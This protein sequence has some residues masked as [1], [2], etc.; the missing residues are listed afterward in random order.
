MKFINVLIE[1]TTLQLNQTFTYAC[2]YDVQ[3]GMRVK[4]PFA[5]QELIAIVMECDVEYTK[6]NYKYVIEVLDAEPLL[7]EEMFEL[8]NYISNTYVTSLMSC[9]K[10]MLPPALRPSSN[11]SLVQYED[12]FVA[13]ASF[14]PLTPKQA[15][16]W[17]QYKE[18]LPMKASLFRKLAKHHTKALLDK[19]Y[20]TIE[21]REKSQT[22]VSVDSVSKPFDLTQEQSSALHEIHTS[23][24]SVFLLHGVTGS[25][26]TEIF[27]RL[28]QEVLDQG[29]QV[30]FLV[31]EIG[32]TPMIISRVMARFQQNIAIYHSQLNASEKYQQY[33]MVKNKQVNIVVGTRS[34]CFMPFH[35]L[36]LILMD[37]EHDTSYKQD[38]MPKYHTRDIVLFRAQKHHCKVVLASA[39]P[40]LESYA[41]A[42][43]GIY[44]L[45]EMKHRVYDQMPSIQLVNLK[46][47]FVQDGLSQTLIDKM[48]DRLAK[49][50]QV[51]L[52]L[53]RR[54]YLP[55]VRCIDCNEVL[56]CPDCG[57]ALSY[58]KSN[59]ALM[60]HCCGNVYPKPS[61]CPSCG[62]RMFSTTGMGTEKLEDKIQERFPQAHVV[63]MDADSTRKKNA[64]E[65]LLKEFEQSG[66][67][68]IGTQMVA[69]GLD[70]PR[71]TLVGI[72]QADSA[73]TR[74][75]YRACE[76]AY[77]MLEQAS[78]RCGREKLAGEVIIQTFDEDHYVMKSVVAHDYAS[79]FA[80]EMQYRHLGQYPPYVYMATLI[81]VHPDAEK[82]RQ[83]ALEAKDFLKE[84]RVLGPIDISM[85]MKKSRVR[86]LIKDK[87]EQHLQA[88]IWNWVHHEKEHPSAVKTEINMHPLMLED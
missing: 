49:N 23:P 65:K 6:A 75:D 35:D 64:H 15:E 21:T 67:I 3:R 12:W 44:H 13:N 22:L 18:N 57:I 4:V 81:F 70:F 45:I 5:H 69:K 27:L 61:A 66:D 54:G 52:L 16:I 72:L 26:K 39:T 41:R 55:T 68:L 11:H 60:C 63:R 79:F 77:E 53:N 10:T 58:H 40:C 74:N 73:L 78:G 46:N 85:R 25:G 7:N 50:E 28:A 30:L 32:L 24:D 17:N 88:Q 14:E 86:L 33:Q 47:D 59:N 83:K 48:E 42:Y 43:K 38:S 62:S 34:A 37:E 36:G 1:H 82:A 56:T 31:P 87:N 8:A 9:F 84:N 2:T 19:G 71:V 29:K 76:V 20:I 80:R 51:I